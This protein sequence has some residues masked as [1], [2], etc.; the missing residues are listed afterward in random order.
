MREG[1]RARAGSAR[2]GW[3][4]GLEWEL[5]DLLLFEGAVY[6]IAWVITRSSL[7]RRAR[8]RVSGAAPLLGELV[9]C[10]VCTSAWVCLGLVPVLPH[11]SLLSPGFRVSTAGDLV[12]LE[13][14][15]V[16]ATWAL[17]RGLGD[18]S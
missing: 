12:V 14:W 1:L 2:G 17:A 15:T 7:L 11:T 3:R 5:R 10:V 6:G 16:A 8:E 9:H 13:G 4:T 18:A